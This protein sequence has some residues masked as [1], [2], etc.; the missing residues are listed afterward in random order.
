MDNFLTRP[1]KGA[2]C[3]WLS[4]AMLVY[5]RVGIS[6][7][8]PDGCH[9]F[10][11][12]PM[13]ID[14]VIDFSGRASSPESIA[15]LWGYHQPWFATAFHGTSRRAQL[16]KPVLWV[17]QPCRAVSKRSQCGVQVQ[18]NWRWRDAGR[19]ALDIFLVLFYLFMALFW[20]S[21][22]KM[23]NN[24]TG[25]A[26]YGSKFLIPTLDDFISLLLPIWC[27]NFVGPWCSLEPNQTKKWR[28]ALGKMFVDGSAWV[29]RRLMRNHTA[30][31]IWAD[32]SW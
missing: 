12:T 25:V 21:G 1:L 27:F 30:K 2:A 28:T 11:F 9:Q 19:R 24:W 29:R 3:F 8:C 15:E 14:G 20:V 17:H 4:T 6:K 16:G 22:R 5:Q 31:I 18:E 13:V 26:R 23:S 32:Q 10:P 7:R